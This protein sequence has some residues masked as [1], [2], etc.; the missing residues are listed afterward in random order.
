MS[1]VSHFSKPPVRLRPEMIVR[2]LMSHM[3]EL[4]SIV[5]VA[6]M[7]GYVPVV[8]ISDGTSPY[9]LSMGASLLHDA[10]LESMDNLTAEKASKNDE[11][12]KEGA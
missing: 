7:K 11:A 5:V 6:K 12:P 8:S 2:W 10:A 4:D 9:L 1:N 3:D